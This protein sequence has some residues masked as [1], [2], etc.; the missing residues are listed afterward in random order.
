VDLGGVSVRTWTY[1]G[2]VP[3]KEIRLQK[4]GSLRSRVKNDLPQET[5]VHWHGLAIPNDMDGVPVLTQ[6]AIARGASWT[7]ACTDR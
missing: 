7:A 1:T 5:T 2:S 6:P 3:A 4:S